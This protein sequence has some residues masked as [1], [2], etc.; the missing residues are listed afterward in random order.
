MS[1]SL[2]H[3][4]YLAFKDEPDLA[5]HLDMIPVSIK[6]LYSSSDLF[7]TAVER[8]NDTRALST[9]A[10]AGA[11]F[12]LAVSTLAIYWINV[13]S[14]PI[15][16]GA[17]GYF[18]LPA[19]IPVIFVVTVFFAV[20]GLLISFLRSVREKES[21]REKIQS[22]IVN[23]EIVIKIE[24]NEEVYR[25]LSEDLKDRVLAEEAIDQK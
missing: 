13:I 24:I 14:Y 23:H 5:K 19:S 3:S 22:C 20:A 17:K 8:R 9:W 25:T 12:G 1:D 21:I 15:Q 16:L 7:H 11:L 6:E 2:L 18:E 10:L 4:V